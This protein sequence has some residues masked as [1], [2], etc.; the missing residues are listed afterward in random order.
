MKT[1]ITYHGSR[2]EF[3]AFS[4]D[5]L[6]SN[7]TDYGAGFYTT[8]SEAY[9]RT[10]AKSKDGGRGYL[11]T[12]EF[13]PRKALSLT[14]RQI[15]EEELAELLLTLHE[16]IDLL[17]NY[18]DVDYYG[19]EAVLTS[20]IQMETQSS[21]NDVDLINGMINGCGDAEAVLNALHEV[22]GYTHIEVLDRAFG[23]DFYI[24]LTP[25]CLNLL[26]CEVLQASSFGLGD[27]D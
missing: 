4:F 22:L 15:S 26:S 1:L 13:Y 11:Y 21:D 9:A 23:G 24:A 20:A 12:Y 7:G 2:N 6:R 17:W 8:T 10:F 19:V 18:D 16:T 14:E 3:E 25:T 27:D 5:H